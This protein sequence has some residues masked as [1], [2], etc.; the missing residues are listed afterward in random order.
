MKVK[1]SYISVYI[2]AFLFSFY[3]SSFT[4]EASHIDIRSQHMLRP[5]IDINTAQSKPIAEFSTK[6]NLANLPRVNNIKLASIALDQYIVQ[7]GE[8]FSFNE[9]VGP[10]TEDRGYQISKIIVKGKESKGYGGGVCQV[11]STLFNA[12]QMAGLEIIE[13]H[14]HS[15]EVPYV[16]KGKDAATSYG[17]ADLKFVNT[18]DLPL[19]INTY[20]YENT[21]NVHIIKL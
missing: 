7:P 2:C 5:I 17:G 1:F 6:F 20:I 18:F 11:S 12:A 10:T 15:K 21:I 16:G 8:T 4:V 3:I 14:P 13:R 19:K 9:V